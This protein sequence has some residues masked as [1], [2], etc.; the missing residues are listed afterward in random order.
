MKKTTCLV[1]L[2]LLLTLSNSR[3]ANPFNDWID[4]HWG[5][6]CNTHHVV[7]VDVSGSMYWWQS[8]VNSMLSTWKTYLQN[9]RT[10]RNIV[11][12][13]HQFHH[14]NLIWPNN[15]KPV[16]SKAPIDWNGPYSG[17]TG[18]TTWSHGIN[19]LIDRMNAAQFDDI[20]YTMITDQHPSN[21]YVN[22]TTSSNFIR[23][24]RRWR[25]K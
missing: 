22:P 1:I 2:V 13:A 10:R 25:Q 7:S 23:A 16:I 9:E 15:P 24:Y 4:T 21:I 18:G 3:L 17:A 11:V 5:N 6:C 12:S 19:F 20:C 8:S 14:S